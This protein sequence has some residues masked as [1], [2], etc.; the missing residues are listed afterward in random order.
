L[1]GNARHLSRVVYGRYS[2]KHFLS[3]EEGEEREREICFWGKLVF[4]KNSSFSLGFLVVRRGNG[5]VF[6]RAPTFCSILLP[7]P[8]VVTDLQLILFYFIYVIK[9]EF[10]KRFKLTLDGNI[11]FSKHTIV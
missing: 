7:Q 2:L 9:L 4:L 10:L 1:G 11:P 5:S 8:T 6:G 3:T